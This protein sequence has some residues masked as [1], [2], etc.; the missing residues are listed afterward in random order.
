MLELMLN[1]FPCVHDQ[2]CFAKAC[3]LSCAHAS[4]SCLRF[5]I[6]LV[7]DRLYGFVSGDM[8]MGSEPI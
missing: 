5:M 8:T 1:Y 2:Q 3:F 6:L 4:A 7:N